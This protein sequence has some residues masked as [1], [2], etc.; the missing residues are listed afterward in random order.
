VK[1]VVLDRDGTLI[2][3][4]H[5]LSDPMQ[6]RVLPTVKDGLLLLRKA[7]ITLVLHT[8]QAGVGKGLFSEQAVLDCN[9]EMLRQ[10]GDDGLFA[11]VCI[12]TERDDEPHVYRKPSPKLGLELMRELKVGPESLCYIGDNV[13]DLLTARNLGCAGIGVA[14]GEHRLRERISD[15]DVVRD[16]PIFDTFVDAAVWAVNR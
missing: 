1:C 10:L 11:R 3:H 14:T 16:F 2:E 12:A 9:R 4:V 7:E 15:I 13:S 8:N 6:V 5:Y